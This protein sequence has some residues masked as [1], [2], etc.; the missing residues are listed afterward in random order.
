MKRL[1]DIRDSINKYRRRSGVNNRTMKPIMPS[2]FSLPC[3]A[4]IDYNFPRDPTK[5]TKDKPV[6]HL[7]GSASGQ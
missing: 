5:N 7:Y 3:P 6:N 1:S 2:I 4:L